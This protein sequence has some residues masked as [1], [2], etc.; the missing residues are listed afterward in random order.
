VAKIE[1]GEHYIDCLDLP[2]S[3]LQLAAET[4][5]LR[6]KLLHARS[7]YGLTATRVQSVDN[8]YDTDRLSHTSAVSCDEDSLDGH[9]V[10]TSPLLECQHCEITPVIET[11]PQ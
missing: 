4:R 8:V 5:Q 2:R 10:T 3:L 9:K 1:S 7:R 6:L 11:S